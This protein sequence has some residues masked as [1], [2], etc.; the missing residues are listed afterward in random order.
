VCRSDLADASDC[1]VQ[2]PSRGGDENG[3]HGMALLRR[4]LTTARLRMLGSLVLVAV[5]SVIPV[6]ASGGATAAAAAG[7]APSRV[8]FSPILSAGDIVTGVRGTTSGK[9]VLTGSEVTGHGAETD[10]FLF[11]GRLS[12]AAVGAQVS[13]LTPP[14]PGVTTATFYGP[15]T[16][17]FNPKAIPAGQVRAV[18]SY[19]SSS[20]PSGVLDRG[21]IYLGPLSGRGGA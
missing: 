11:R 17:S 16:H 1:I 18:G 7:S 9:V 21:M 13:L 12:R 10:A 15:D 3:V 2:A 20:S 6:L 19:Q 4:T 5:A 8:S 14:F